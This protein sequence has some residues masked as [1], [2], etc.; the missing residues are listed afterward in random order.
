M[1]VFLEAVRLSGEEEELH[2]HLAQM[3]ERPVVGPALARGHVPVL[4]AEKDDRRRLD[5]VHLEQGSEPDVELRVL[6]RRFAK[7][8]GVK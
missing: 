4:G 5:L 6:E 7:I 3:V 2:G 8:V 1:G